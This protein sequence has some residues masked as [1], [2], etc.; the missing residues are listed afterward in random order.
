M[1]CRC[2]RGEKPVVLIL[3]NSVLHQRYMKL[4]LK[5][6]SILISQAMVKNSR[7]I[8]IRFNNP[9]LVRVG[10]FDVLQYYYIFIW[11]KLLMEIPRV[12]SMF[13]CSFCSSFYGNH[14]NGS[15]RGSSFIFDTREAP[16]SNFHLKIR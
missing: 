13:R 11:S 2:G 7:K 16:L 3:D 15:Q 6:E 1:K 4:K 10:Y 14:S 12:T 9:T 5:F 8:K